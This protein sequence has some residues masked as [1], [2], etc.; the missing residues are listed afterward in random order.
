VQGSI[1]LL[2]SWLALLLPKRG[3]S[4]HD[5]APTLPCLLLSSTRCTQECFASTSNLLRMFALNSKGGATLVAVQTIHTP[6]QMHLRAA[7]R[8]VE[9]MLMWPRMIACAISN[10]MTTSHDIRSTCSLFHRQDRGALLCYGRGRGDTV[11]AS[12]WAS[13]SVRVQVLARPRTL[14]LT[15]LMKMA[16]TAAISCLYR[17]QASVEVRTRKFFKSVE[18]R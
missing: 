6:C 10:S 12:R 15:L 11:G 3:L 9:H 7:E 17:E 2:C 14:S 4:C 16:G 1:L 5:V 13:R 8:I 18:H